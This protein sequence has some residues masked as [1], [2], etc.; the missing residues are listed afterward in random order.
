MP[1]DIN[2]TMPPKMWMPKNVTG[3]PLRLPFIQQ[4]KRFPCPGM[5]SVEF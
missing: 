4:L 2:R 3:N 5:I 1:S